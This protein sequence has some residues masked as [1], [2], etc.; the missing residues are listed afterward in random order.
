MPEQAFVHFELPNGLNAYIY[1]TGKF[2]TTTVRLFFHHQLNETDVT[3]NA[4]YPNVLRRGTRR[5]PT[6]RDLARQL[7]AYFGARASVDVTKR[8]DDQIVS[9]G[10]DAIDDYYVPGGGRLLYDG[11]RLLSDLIADPLVV[12]GAFKPEYVEGE[13]EVLRRDIESLMND[14][15]AYAAWRCLEET[16]QGDPYALLPAGRL[17]DLLG[18]TPRGLYEYYRRSLATD[19]ADLYIVG[20]VNPDAVRR[21]IE[22][23]FVIP[24]QTPAPRPQT[25]AR[26]GEG[27][28]RVIS[29]PHDVSQAKLVMASLTGINAGDPR[30]H[31]LLVYNGILG[32]FPHS[33]LFR[34]VREKA[35]LC[36]YATSG[37]ERAKGILLIQSGIESAQFEPAVAIIREQLKAI[38]DGA[39]SDDELAFTKRALTA[40][41]RMADD[42]PGQIISQHLDGVICGRPLTAA[43]EMA[44]IERVT[45]DDVVA[46]AREIKLETI[47]LL[48][49]EGDER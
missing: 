14:K 30:Y 23:V 36:Y 3:L 4:L 11:L 40:R 7:E 39:V 5:L 45:R 16:L 46:V 10:I 35:S 6:T 29:E 2:K 22:E 12:D 8:G 19:P 37:I 13:K 24:R 21:T 20:D 1:Q 33:K 32:G 43:E 17:E 48:R 26:R 31:A 15:A 18:I 34:N 38:A 42:S 47:Y 49:P 27:A 44:A 25:T 41:L 28:E 9:V